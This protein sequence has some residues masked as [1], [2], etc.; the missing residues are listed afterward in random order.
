MKSNLK[1][2]I[3][4][5]LFLLFIIFFLFSH[6]TF[7][8]TP[9]SATGGGWFMK[10]RYRCA[11]Q[12]DVNYTAGET[13]PSGLLKYSDQEIR[14]IV[15]SASITSFI[16]SDNKATIKGE[17]IVNRVS[18][19]TFIF[20]VTD[21]SPDYVSIEIKD[22]EGA[23]YYNA[24]GSLAY[25]DVEISITGPPTDIIPPRIS[26]S[27]QD[28]SVITETKPQIAITYSDAESGIDS[29]TFYVEIN[30]V[31][32]TSLFAITD[33]Q[34]TY[35]VVTDLPIGEN[36]IIA[37]ISDYAGNTS[38]IT[39]KFTVKPLQ[40]IPHASPTSGVVP[41]TVTFTPEAIDTVGTVIRYQWDYNGDG[42]YDRTDY[43]PTTSRYTYRTPGVYQATLKVIDNVGLTDEASITIAVSSAPPVVSASATPTNGPI[44]LTVNFTGTA[45]SPNGAIVKY[46]WDFDGDGVYDWES[47]TSPNTSYT[48]YSVGTFYATLQVTDVANATATSSIIIRP[49]PAGSPTVNVS[50]S[51]TNGSAPLTV[52]FSGSATSPNGDIIRYEWDFDNDG[53]FDWSSETSADVT[54]TYYEGGI[55]DAT[56]KAIDEAGME[57]YASIRISVNI[58]LS[59]TRDKDT[60][61]PNQGD[62]VTVTTQYSGSAT[63]NILVKDSNGQIVRYLVNGEERTAGTYEDVW[64][65][66]DDPGNIVS[67]G[68]YYFVAEAIMPGGLSQTYDLTGTGITGTR[69][70]IGGYRANFPYTFAPYEDQFC[71]ITYNVPVA[72]KVVAD[73]CPYSYYG[74]RVRTLLQFEPQGRGSHTIYW[75]GMKDDGTMVPPN[76][77]W[78]V[79]IW[80]Y[81]I[82]PNGVVVEGS[83]P[84]I[85][86][87]S[88]DPNYYCP[89]EPI[90][91]GFRQLNISFTLSKTANVIVKIYDSNNTLVR[92]ISQSNLPAGE[93]TI[94]W[95]GKNEVGE[96]VIDTAY[97]VGIKAIDNQGNHSL[98]RYAHVILF[99]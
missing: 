4:I 90:P 58:I 94:S 38:T 8:N 37:Q 71:T 70:S 26:I 23:T 56:L 6:K 49:Q 74:E 83:K 53:I 99:Y 60:I 55:F 28:G 78:L 31:D 73:I 57:G 48:Y 14:L 15:A 34:A 61:N 7:A 75:D 39:S 46:E 18:G 20:E 29:A 87:L 72:G 82:S 16:V 79:T 25:G 96:Y 88:A 5:L 89:D 36:V 42:I 63:I 13:A 44:P 52:H 41:L 93:N 11:F 9:G 21:G 12:V 67:D 97:H 51:P 68:A 84:E 59:L 45:S 85:T 50:A 32:S 24:A 69:R 10:G 80:S 30:G 19:Y 3:Q 77:R 91:T 35:Q 64:D 2:K 81:D 98:T 27:P 40:A 33:T 22:S 86:D 43:I 65:G 1:S 17:C 76:T 47:D 54:Y 92:T 62:T 66:T 95:D